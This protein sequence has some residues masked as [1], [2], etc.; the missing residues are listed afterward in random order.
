M[1]DITQSDPNQFWSSLG[2]LRAAVRT[3]DREQIRAAIPEP[4]EFIPALFALE[5]GDR[6]TILTGVFS[7]LETD[8]DRW[9]FIE[10]AAMHSVTHLGQSPLLS[11]LPQVP[12][13][14]LE[15]V[16]HLMD[17]L[18]ETESLAAVRQTLNMGNR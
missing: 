16:H 2:D 10:A 13:N 12:S 5:A 4:P 7:V 3:G 11:L 18:P 1:K 14:P 15:D 9:E 8:E 17:H 6:D